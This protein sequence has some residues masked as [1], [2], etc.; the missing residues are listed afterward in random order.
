MEFDAE[1]IKAALTKTCIYAWALER[2]ILIQRALMGAESCDSLT[3]TDVNR[4]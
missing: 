2:Q 1:I 4:L 3:S